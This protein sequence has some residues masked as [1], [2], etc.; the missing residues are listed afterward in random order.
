MLASFAVI[1]VGEG[2]E[3]QEHIA[4][5][6]ELID[7]SGLPYKLGAMQ[8]TLEGDQ[9]QVMDVIMRCHNL[10][11]ERT[12]RVLTSIT[13]DDR[14]GAVDRLEGKVRDVETVLGRKV[15]HE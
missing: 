1:P 10:M 11:R 9:S 5:I 15:N 6:V 8:T 4:A 13:I 7:A 12:S 14:K 2:E 3:L